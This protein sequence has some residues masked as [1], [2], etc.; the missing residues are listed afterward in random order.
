MNGNKGRK[1][2][3]EHIEKRIAWCRGKK[4]SEEHKKK[5][6]LAKKG[7]PTGRS[8][9]K[10]IPCTQAVKDKVSKALKGRKNT[11][12]TYWGE[13]HPNWKVDGVG[14]TALHQRIRK[15]LGKPDTCEHCKKSGLKGQQIHWANK[16]NEYK[17]DISDWIR[18]CA[19]CHK[20]YDLHN[21]ISPVDRSEI[22]K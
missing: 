10:G 6:S 19:K 15:I 1:Q 11:W 20:K 8:W 14:Y 4:L 5:L 12:Q 7:K 18:L 16:S 13:E 3:K 9:N 2:T 17:Q 21:R 22:Y